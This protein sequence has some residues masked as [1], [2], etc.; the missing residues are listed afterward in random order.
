[1]NKVSTSE[2]QFNNN[3][4][5]ETGNVEIV[6]WFV[7]VCQKKF[8]FYMYTFDQ[9]SVLFIDGLP[10]FVC[11]LGGITVSSHTARLIKSRLIE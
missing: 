11:P 7:Q 3:K 4:T 2:N 9:S 5:T 8:L 10:F 1:M 6:R